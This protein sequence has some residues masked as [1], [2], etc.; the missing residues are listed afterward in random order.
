MT[1]DSLPKSSYHQLWIP[2]YRTRNYSLGYLHQ[3]MGVIFG[4]SWFRNSYNI[5]NSL[6]D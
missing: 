2:L 3:L 1:G 5:R 6:C 4:Y